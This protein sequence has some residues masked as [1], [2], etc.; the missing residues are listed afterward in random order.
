MKT[1]IPKD[2]KSEAALK[3]CILNWDVVVTQRGSRGVVNLFAVDFDGM[4]LVASVDLREVIK[5][6][7]PL[8]GVKKQLAGIVRGKAKKKSAKKKVK[9]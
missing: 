4:P 6:R 7:Q 9:K 2:P 3:W 8:T 5:K 1:K